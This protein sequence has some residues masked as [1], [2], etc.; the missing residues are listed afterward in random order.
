M[1]VTNTDAVLH[2]NVGIFG[3]LGYG[4]PNFGNDVGS[5][6]PQILDLVNSMGANLFHIMHHQD[7]DMRTP[8]SINTLT[9]LH[10]LYVRTGKILEGRAIAPGE[11]NMET[12]HVSPG[13]EVFMVFPCPYFKVRNPYIKR[14]AGLLMMALSEAMQHTENRKEMEI[15]TTFAGLVDQY[16]RR[17]YVNMAV[18]MFGI[19]RPT[20]SA[21]GFIMTAE[22]LAGYDPTKWFTGTEM[23]DTVPSLANVMTEDRLE[24]LREGIPVTQ[25]PDLKPYPVNLTSYYEL[26]RNG[27]GST[28]SSDAN[29]ASGDRASF[30]T[31]GV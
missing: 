28:G 30:P 31:P 5:L 17:V 10:K 7:V 11:L 26:I 6:N 21:P 27:G 3:D 4:V 22:Q 19:D 16:L 23:V 14:W 15:S 12:R 20:A 8:P 9:R 29:A 13:G 1:P 18:E 24:T 2:Y 25:L